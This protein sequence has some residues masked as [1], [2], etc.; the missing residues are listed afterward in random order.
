MQYSMLGTTTDDPVMDRA[1][2]LQA[3][4]NAA[5]RQ[6]EENP[7]RTLDRKIRDMEKELDALV[8]DSPQGYSAGRYYTS[9]SGLVRP[10]GTVTA[11]TSLVLGAEEAKRERKPLPWILL[12]LAAA[13][14][15]TFFTVKA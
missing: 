4:L 14:V 13:G 1:R 10:A 15:A 2:E 6:A 8:G 3:M 5:Y 7:S 11:D 9:E 12:G